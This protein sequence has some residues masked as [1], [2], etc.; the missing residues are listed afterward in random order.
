[1]GRE[2]PFVSGTERGEG[3]RLVIPT[4]HGKE[5][6]VV[7]NGSIISEDEVQ[8]NGSI[9]NGRIDDKVTVSFIRINMAVVRRIGL[10]EVLL[11]TV[12][13]VRNIFIG[14]QMEDGGKRAEI[15]SVGKASKQ[16]GVGRLPNVDSNNMGRGINRRIL[17]VHKGNNSILVHGFSGVVSRFENLNYIRETDIGERRR[18]VD[19]QDFRKLNKIGCQAD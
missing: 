17:P 1:M 11:K 3:I 12:K 13:I 7:Q 14:G 8:G 4:V 19:F 16:N 6:L 15:L 5:I 18:L 9:V 10:K 2:I